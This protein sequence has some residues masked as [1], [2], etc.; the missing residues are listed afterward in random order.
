MLKLTSASPLASYGR[1]EIVEFLMNNGADVSL[2]DNEGDTCLHYCTDEPCMRFLVGHGA[3]IHA[4]NAEDLSPKQLL[5][6]NHKEEI[7]T[8]GESVEAAKLAA[9]VQYLQSLE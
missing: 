1:K 5:E 3:D 6:S 8:N 2:K 4:K 9:C 7:E